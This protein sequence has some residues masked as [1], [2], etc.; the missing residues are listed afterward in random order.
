VAADA[1]ARA[2]AA[3][4]LSAATRIHS[5]VSAVKQHTHMDRAPV[6]EPLRVQAHVADAITLLGSK[7][8]SR[9]ITLAL[10]VAGEPPPVMGTIAE[11][12]QAWVHLIDNAIDAAPD[13]GGISIAVGAAQGAVVVRVVDDGPGIPEELRERVFEPFFTTKD[14]GQGRGLGLDIVRTVVHAH[15]GHV[16][17]DSVPGRTEFRVTLPVA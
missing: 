13:D 5:L 12:N 6:M 3:D 4:I 11:L 8:S 15:R 16:Q 2:L 14:V 7:A 9:G 1:D 10:E 17:L